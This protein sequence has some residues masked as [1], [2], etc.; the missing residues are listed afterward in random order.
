MNR[1]SLPSTVT[2]PDTHAELDSLALGYVGEQ[3]PAEAE[4]LLGQLLFEY[5]APLIKTIAG[6]RLGGS[7]ATSQDL[8]D[9][10]GNALLDLIAKIGDV[11]AGAA[12]AIESFS[13]YTAVVAYHACNDYFRQK[14]PQRHRLKNRLRYLLKPERGFDL[15]ESARGNSICGL[16]Q[17]RD[18]GVPAGDLRNTTTDHAARMSPPDLLGAIFERAGGPLEFDALVDLVAEL[19]GVKDQ[20]VTVNPA[21]SLVQAAPVVEETSLRT[22]LEE[23]WEQIAE[24]PLAQ[25]LAL[26][27][28]LRAHEEEC[29][30]ELF[31]LTG[32]ASVREI[33]ALLEIPPEEFALLWRELPLDDLAI[34]ERLQVT[35]QQVINLRKSARRR[36]E[37]RRTAIVPENQR[38]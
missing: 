1:R 19:W 4:R 34:A 13:G 21:L 27:L 2:R 20:A 23:L 5:C 7:A 14:F 26:L 6:P 35:R 11:R 17:W 29:A 37:R 9:V 32:V 10:C 12:Q 36:L 16:R 30:L 18:S 38:R 28:N 22:R 24:L 31:P 8:D 3:D 15:W 33:A 25:R